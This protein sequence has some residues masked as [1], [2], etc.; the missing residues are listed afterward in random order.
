MVLFCQ[1][2]EAELDGYQIKVSQLAQMSDNL[3]KNMNSSTISMIKSRQSLLEQRM[4]ALRQ[5]LSQQMSVLAND[6][7]LMGRFNKAFQV[8][9]ITC[10]S[11]AQHVV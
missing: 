8:S 11:C 3:T 1:L 10:L 6:M 2:M 9:F 7:S 4:V 5:V